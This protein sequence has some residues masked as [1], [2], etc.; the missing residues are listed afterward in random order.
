[1]NNSKSGHQTLLSDNIGNPTGLLNYFLLIG[2]VFLGFGLRYYQL[3]G[4]L[5]SDEVWINSTANSPFPAFYQEFMQDWVHPPFFHFL[6]RAWVY[7]FGL[8][9]VSGRLVALTFGVLSIPL[10]YWLGKLISGSKVGLMAG[11]LLAL[12]PTHIYHSQYGRHYS[13]FIFF[14]LLSMIAFL[15]VYYQ[16]SDR[17][18]GIFYILSSM[19]LV[20]THYFGWLILLCQSLFF[21][22]RRFTFLRRWVLLQAVILLSYIPWIFLVLKFTSGAASNQ[23]LAP[24]SNQYLVPHIRWMKPPYISELLNTIALFNGN[25]PL[26]HQ[27]NMGLFLLGGIS[28]LSMK[29]VFGKDKNYRDSILFLFSCVVI[30][31]ILVYVVSRTIQPIW[32]FRGMLLSVPA[33]YLLISLGSQQFPGKK[34]SIVLMIIPIL[35]MSL[36]SW[37]YIRNE[38]RMPFEQ[39]TE[40]L[41]NESESGDPILVENSWLANSLFHYYKGKGALYELAESNVSVVPVSHKKNL[42][43]ILDQKRESGNRLILVTY[44]PE[45]AD[46]IRGEL[47]PM[48]RFAKLNRFFGYGEQGQREFVDIFVF[49]K[50]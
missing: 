26:F 37:Y 43:S 19:L 1:M 5:Y 21:L 7:V 40:Y 39:I 14:V 24:G 8:S 27:R 22:F 15:K 50:R 4:N 28:I 29:S 6:A 41:E 42:A 2:I 33:Y 13:L 48:Y 34:I 45:T 44:Q 36:A 32:V 31:F 38:H 10:I 47:F 9:D 12:S 35:W 30:P 17:N 16:P 3:A 49:K 11:S 25:L 20:Y 46:E 18:S 23:L